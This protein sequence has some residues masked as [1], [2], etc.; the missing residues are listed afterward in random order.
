M[1]VMKFVGTSVSTAQRMKEVAKL[2]TQ[3]RENVHVVH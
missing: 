1:K 2:V 3:Y